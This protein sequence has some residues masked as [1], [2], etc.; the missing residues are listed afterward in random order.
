MVQKWISIVGFVLIALGTASQA[1]ADWCF[2]IY[3]SIASDVKRRQAW[4]EPFR[5]PDEA[6][7]RAPFDIMI[8]NGWR[9]Q[10]TLGEFHFEPGTGQLTEAGRLKAQTILVAVPQPYRRIY[11]HQAGTEEETRA[12]MTSVMQWVN[13]HAPVN[14]PE[15]LPTNR[16]DYGWPAERVEM[17]G[18]KFQSTTPSPRLP[19][20]AMS[21]T[22]SG[23]GSTSK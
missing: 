2:G 15:V 14:P 18:R 6:S 5:T 7:A 22:T 3:D 21:G 9:R 16:P 17:I 10:N 19:A 12:R 13:Q 8:H 23:S 11:V 4:P 20:E 1:S